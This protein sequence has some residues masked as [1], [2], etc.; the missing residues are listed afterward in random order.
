MAAT[1]KINTRRKTA[2]AAQRRGTRP[3]M[4]ILVLGLGV[5]L[6]A[7]LMMSSNA[8]LIVFARKF[9]QGT[10]GSLCLLLPF[11]VCWAG[12]TMA[13]SEKAQ[14][15]NRRMFLVAALFVLVTT[16][17]Q[18]FQIQDMRD[19]NMR[20]GAEDS[21]MRFIELTAWRSS[22]I[23]VGGGVVGALLA[24]PLWSALD[25]WGAILLLCV[26]IL[27]DLVL[28]TGVAFGDTGAR[29]AGWWRDARASMAAYREDKRL[30][31]EQRAAQ[32]AQEEEILLYD[33]PP[34]EAIPPRQGRKRQAPLP[35]QPGGNTARIPA[36]DAL[37]PADPYD[38]DYDA[39]AAYEEPYS[40]AYE[41]GYEEPY[42]EPSA[43]R[44]SRRS[45]AGRAEAARPAGAPIRDAQPWQ[46]AS[47]QPAGRA[48]YVERVPA[49]DGAPAPR[50]GVAPAARAASRQQ[51]GGAT[52]G[53]YIENVLS[54]A[55]D[56]EPATGSLR[57][58]RTP[59]DRVSAR[60]EDAPE[61]RETAVQP[62]AGPEG[63]DTLDDT[64]P[65]DD[66]P[67]DDEPAP[68]SLPQAET[69]GAPRRRLDE[70][71]L[72]LPAKKKPGEEPQPEPYRF[73]PLNLLKQPAV[74]T[75]PDTRAQDEAGA[76]KLL[77]TLRSFGIQAKV[78]NVTHG[79]AITRYELQ[80]AP[81]VKVSRIVGLAD[82][83]AL[84][85]A[86]AGGVRIEAPIP[87]KP[88]VGIEISNE[89][90]STVTLREVLDSDELRRQTSALACALG[91]DI[92]GRR[93]VADL[94]KMP[95][96]LIAGA[97]GS[98]KSVCINTLICSLIYR[99]APEEV[100]MILIDP[101]VVEL[102]VYNG[103]PHLLL[104]VVTDPKKAS[105]ALSWAVSEM[106]Q[107]Y[108]RFAEQGVRD[109]R[110]FNAALAEEEP[111]MTQIV[112]I[113]DEL[114]DLM[115][116]APGEV[117]E[118][119]C[120]LAQLARAAGIHLVI[121]TQRP[122]VNVITGVIKANIP[123]RVAFAV[124][125]QVDSRTILDGAGAEKLLGKGDMLY[126]P[127]GTGKPTR[128][129]GCFV[130]DEEVSRVVDFVKR[131]HTAE[132][133]ED[134]I[135]YL[136]QVDTGGPQNGPGDEQGE[137]DE[138]L[139]QAIEIILE[140]GQASISMLQRRLRVGYARAGRLIDEMA[141]R[142]IVAQAEGSKP[143]AVLFT[144]E[145]YRRMYDLD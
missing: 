71:P 51:N 130:S 138:L 129:Q 42:E 136:E 64:A 124:S 111:A 126:A 70:T 101:K 74:R 40:P 133:S 5:L 31:R 1:K 37:S 84:N 27:A 137:S 123:S 94:A 67:F 113:I 72:G 141:R 23:S 76:G 73:P 99:A 66:E 35:P 139:A 52:G 47:A 16:F 104:P 117:E 8:P 127:Q 13:F 24:W 87:G 22:E 122:S 6:F 56:G 21:Y 118:S 18:L 55:G 100:R 4:G 12:L 26:L 61:E 86:S 105:G 62:D 7:C 32:A 144:R 85:M 38:T 120:R 65:W 33:A 91:K 75:A 132:Y 89:N 112:V 81:G 121:A 2:P 20:T 103:I 15:N 69:P 41:A 80:P 142:G 135:E 59:V 108:R 14:V 25:L 28:L 119:I 63:A 60:H 106:E 39:E 134:I 102:S 125:S 109:I 29:L 17:I 30:Q 95:H 128:V 96:V 83:I 114:A 57:R 98:G 77:E 43:Q 3:A 10:A 78:L 44:P 9:L 46:G 131:R 145:E 58:R 93:V 54:Q 19:Y 53:L 115:M 48:L 36:M 34:A 92:A 68:E 79:P 116:V 45:A 143:R 50:A 88:A 140:S 97:T 110:G 49:G 11:L 107:R 90:I 82:D